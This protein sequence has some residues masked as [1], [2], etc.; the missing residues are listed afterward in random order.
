MLQSIMRMN[1]F[2]SEQIHT[3]REYY[4]TFLINKF[5]HRNILDIKIVLKMLKDNFRQSR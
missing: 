4:I 5:I 2:C 3:H 1:V